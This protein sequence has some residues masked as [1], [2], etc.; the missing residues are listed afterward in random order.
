MKES[1]EIKKADIR[2]VLVVK[3]SSLG[4]IIHVFPALEILRRILPDAEIDFLV[5][6]K[7]AGLLDYSPVKISKKVLF[8]REK[9][10]KIGSFISGS[11]QLRRELRRGNYDLVIDFQGLFRSAFFSFL[12]GA[13]LGVCGFASPRERISA[14]FYRSKIKCTAVHAVEKNVELVNGI[15][16]TAYRV[17]E[18]DIPP[19]SVELPAGIPERYTVL[20][21]GARWNSKRFP[22]ELFAQIAAAL[23]AENRKVV[24]A[25]SP[26]EEPLCREISEAC[27]N[28]ANIVSCAG[29]T[30]MSELFELIR[31]AD[32]VVC[33]DSGPLHIASVMNKK[34]FCFFGS[35]VPEKTG[36]WNSRAKIYGVDTGCRGCLKRECPHSEIYC[37]KIDV[38]QV[39]KDILNMELSL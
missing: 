22:V 32:A 31:R 27:G 38:H 34:I 14:L 1:G 2:R 13:K 15:F 35:T 19:G 17:P 36:P 29:K 21:P 28:D 5:N 25:G 33:N 37:H 3:P 6:P 10:G 30:G 26:D 24:L 4:D 18:C 16:N 9:L 23:A 8:E 39:I 12:A 11:M 20:L 7:F